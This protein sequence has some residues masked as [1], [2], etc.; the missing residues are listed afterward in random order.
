MFI[1]DAFG[2]S[3]QSLQGADLLAA[4]LS[5]LGTAVIMPDFFQGKAA[6]AEWFAPDAGEAAK[7]EKAAFW[8]TASEYEKWSQMTTDLVT[9][10]GKKWE[11]VDGWASLGLCWG[12]K[13]GFLS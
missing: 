7:A 13:V 11:G 4:A 1:Y 3:P 2:V 6:K 12:G 8:G 5:P 9:E 10:F